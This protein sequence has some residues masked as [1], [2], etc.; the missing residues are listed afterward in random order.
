MVTYVNEIQK[1]I[2]KIWSDFKSILNIEKPKRDL[3]A[4]V[5]ELEDRENIRELLATYT[6]YWNSKDVDGIIRIMS[7]DCVILHGYPY[8]GVFKGKEQARNFFENILKKAPE[9]GLR[10]Q[11]QED[12]HHITNITIR[13][14]QE[15]KRANAH[16]YFFRVSTGKKG[17]EEAGVIATGWYFFSLKKEGGEWKVQQMRIERCFESEIFKVKH[18]L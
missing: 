14:D 9:K 7:D 12:K 18:Y 2:S 13:V 17:E 1:S 16:T 4:K 5:E 8:K 3:S 11:G 6:Y 10:L 15:M